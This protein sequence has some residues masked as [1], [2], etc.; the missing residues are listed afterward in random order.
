MITNL[1]KWATKM[2][3]SPFDMIILRENEEN[4]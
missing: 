1:Q 3:G 2:Q 4:D